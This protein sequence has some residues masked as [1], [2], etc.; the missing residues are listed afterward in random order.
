MIYFICILSVHLFSSYKC[1]IQRKK[2]LKMSENHE[3]KTTKKQ[4]KTQ[5]QDFS[6]SSDVHLLD[7]SE[8][9][10]DD[11]NAN[12]G[13]EKGDRIVEK[14]LKKL[15]FG[16]S[17]LLD[18]DNK[19]IAG[20]HVLKGSAKQGFNKKIITVDVDGDTIVAVRRTDLT[21]DSAKGRQ[22]AIV[23]NHSAVVGIDLSQEVMLRQAEEHDFS[24]D[25]FEIVP[26][27]IMDDY[28]EKNKEV[29]VDDF[30]DNCTITLNY[31]M[32]EYDKVKTALHGIAVTPEQAIWKLLNL[33][34]YE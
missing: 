13:T 34:S 6:L 27:E 10:F 15:G 7:M 9:H 5:K 18:K 31:T 26:I 17:V 19:V 14:S 32:E 11:D 4:S 28:S 25:D 29:D 20:N 30:D 22:M 23:D 8:I 21:L 1:V 3:I 12:M 16:R 24:L 2:S 33:D